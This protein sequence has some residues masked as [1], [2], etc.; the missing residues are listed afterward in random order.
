MANASNPYRNPVVS[1]WSAI[2]MPVF[3]KAETNV[4]TALRNIVAYT[5]M[6]MTVA[7]RMANPHSCS[8]HSSNALVGWEPAAGCERRRGVRRHTVQGRAAA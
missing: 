8:I 1:D 4:K 2:T 3:A 6:Q 7:A 5:A